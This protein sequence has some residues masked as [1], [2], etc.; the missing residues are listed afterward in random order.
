MELDHALDPP[1][2][3][4]RVRLFQHLHEQS[5]ELGGDADAG[6]FGEEGEGNVVRIR[7]GGGGV[8][9]WTEFDVSTDLGLGELEGFVGGGFGDGGGGE[10]GLDLECDGIDWGG[11]CGGGGGGCGGCGFLAS[12][13][14]LRAAAADILGWSFG[15]VVVVGVFAFVVFLSF[16]WV[17]CDF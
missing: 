10:E 2:V 4:Y 11:G 6:V 12:C 7:F 1:L 9:V 8:V 16:M 14:R 5:Q 15:L 17:S 13:L 3:A